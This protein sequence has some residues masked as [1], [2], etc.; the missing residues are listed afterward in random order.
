VV[1]GEVDEVFR[2]WREASGRR[3]GLTA[4]RRGA[5][6][7]ALGAGVGPAALGALVR[8]AHQARTPEARWLRGENPRGRAYLDLD[9]LLRVGKLRRRVDDALAWEASEA[10]GE[11]LG[12][13]A[14]LRVRA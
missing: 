5:I 14:A 2:A 4:G 13:T 1:A 10:A 9:N 3:G 12:P 7:R 6:E 8:W 11:V